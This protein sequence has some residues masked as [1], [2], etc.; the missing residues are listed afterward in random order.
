V[1]RI[2]ERR[3]TQ[4]VDSRAP[5]DENGSALTNLRAGLRDLQPCRFDANIGAESEGAV[6]SARERTSRSAVL[7]DELEHPV[8]DGDGHIV[9]LMPVFLDYVRDAGHA[10][11]LQ[12]ILSRKRAIEDLSLDER[13]RGGVLPHSWHVPAN[14]EYYATVTSPKRYHERL[15]EA[16]IDFAVLYPS[17]GISFLQL[18]DDEQRVTMCRVYNEFMA[19]Q[20]GPYR[21]RFTVAALVP[22]HTPDEALD[23]LEHA[24]GLGAK[25]AL[26]SSHVH[27]SPGGASLTSDDEF[28]DVRV[29]EWETRGWIDT[30]GIDSVYDYDPVWAKAIELQLPLGAHTAGIGASDR[31]SISNF[32]F[33]Q[34]G[35]FA[36]AGGALAKSLFLGGVTARFPELRLALLEGGAAI[37]VQIYV[38]LVTNWQ[39]RGGPAIA[40][41][42]PENIDKELLVKLLVESD[43]SLARFAPEQLTGRVGSMARVCDDFAAANIT[44]IEDIRDRFCTNFFWGCEAD[45]PLVGVAFDRRVTPLGALVPAFFASDLGHWDV[46]EFDEPLEEAFEL[47]EHGIIDA[48]Q[49]RDFVFANPVRFYASLDRDFFAGTAIANDV[50]AAQA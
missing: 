20:Y 45:D 38:S 32:V 17:A 5:R 48:D 9:E 39:K 26:I 19:E 8:I 42:D 50:A 16:G 2:E 47:V 1:V 15:G 28:G 35:H 41:L 27:R 46:P 36:A 11:V 25:V 30:F 44:A 3:T 13:R 22:M 40:A 10:G 21:D 7:R 24:K 43:P 37:G 18:P 6:T 4:A 23:A 12:G 49:L 29:P 33:N 34:I 14:T 31:A